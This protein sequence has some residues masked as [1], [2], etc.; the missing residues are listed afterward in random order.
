MALGLF[1]LWSEK[2]SGNE[3]LVNMCP[4]RRSSRCQRKV[5]DRQ[6]CRCIFTPFDDPGPWKEQ[7]VDAI[8]KGIHSEKIPLTGLL[9]GIIQE[10][11]NGLIERDLGEEKLLAPIWN[12]FES[13]T[14]EELRHIFYHQEKEDFLSHLE[15]VL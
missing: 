13:N 5:L 10:A 15:I 12:V 9:E 1:Q 4:P 11:T 7:G 2:A 3:V 8:E 14:I 6:F